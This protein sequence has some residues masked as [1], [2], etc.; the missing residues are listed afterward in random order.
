MLPII[1]RRKLLNVRLT[2]C[3]SIESGDSGGE[4]VG[5]VGLLEIK[6]I[7]KYIYCGHVVKLLLASIIKYSW[8]DAH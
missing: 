4:V 1:P 6:Y 2:F 8:N 5:V 7:F 3:G